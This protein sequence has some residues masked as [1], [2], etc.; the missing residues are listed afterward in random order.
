MPNPILITKTKARVESPTDRVLKD[1]TTWQQRSLLTFAVPSEKGHF[2]I[3]LAEFSFDEELPINVVPSSMQLAQ[4]LE[5]I[6][7][8]RF[9]PPV[10]S[11]I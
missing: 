3:E 11:C 6:A 1:I 10:F 7:R 2:D 9:I 4:D 5:K 8:G